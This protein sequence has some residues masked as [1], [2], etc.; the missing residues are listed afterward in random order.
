M[1]VCVCVSG[2]G[3]IVLLCE[4]MI[5]SLCYYVDVYV[6]ICECVYMCVDDRINTI[7]CNC[8]SI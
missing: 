7:L 6:C 5:A 3:V 4:C 1:F 2:E 8:M